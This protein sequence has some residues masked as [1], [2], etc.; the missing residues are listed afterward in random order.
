VPGCTHRADLAERYRSLFEDY[1]IEPGA[2]SLMRARRVDEARDK[3][4]SSGDGWAN[5][6]SALMDEPWDLVFVVFTST[7]T[8]QHF[9]WSGEQRSVVEQVYEAQDR[10]TAMLVDK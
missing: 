3:A 6:T 10:A 4:L 2:P 5:V 1:S 9:F 7:D 8:A